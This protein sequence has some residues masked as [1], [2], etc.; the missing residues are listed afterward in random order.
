M[1]KSIPTG[2]PLT[3]LYP[4]PLHSAHHCLLPPACY[5]HRVLLHF[6]QDEFHFLRGGEGGQTPAQVVAVHSGIV[7]AV[8]A[9]VDAQTGLTHVAPPLSTQMGWE[10]KKNN[11]VV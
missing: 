9:G 10:K 6:I 3:P 7:V 1:I 8:T 11:E 5:L 4:L 2:Q